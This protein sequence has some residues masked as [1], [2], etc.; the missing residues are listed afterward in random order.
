MTR[1]TLQKARK[2]YTCGRCRNEIKPGETYYA[3]AFFRQSVQK[4]CQLC[5]PRASETEP[6]DKLQMVYAADESVKDA[7]EYANQ[8][9]NDPDLSGLVE[10]LRAASET[11]REAAGMWEEIA[12]SEYFQG[13]EQNQTAGENAEAA[14]EFASQLEEAAGDIEQGWEDFEANPESKKSEDEQKAE[15]REELIGKANVECPL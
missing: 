9:G 13:S 3:W 2:P 11:V 12:N 5:C 4:R 14:E 1:V 7:I 8:P 10:D 6:N 15:L